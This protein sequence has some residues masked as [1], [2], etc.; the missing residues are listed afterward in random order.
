M[1]CVLNSQEGA[2]ERERLY[3]FLRE[4]GSKTNPVMTQFCQEHGV[5]HLVETPVDLNGR[6]EIVV[7]KEALEPI[8]YVA[9]PYCPSCAS[10]HVG[11]CKHPDRAVELGTEQWGRKGLNI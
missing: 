11:A 8:K 5:P 9:R 1:S 3:A 10:Y 2:D 6:R 4:A 7:D